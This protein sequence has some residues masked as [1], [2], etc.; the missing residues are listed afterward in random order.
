MPQMN[1]LLHIAHL[2]S[3]VLPMRKS[4]RRKFVAE[5]VQLEEHIARVQMD[6]DRVPPG[7]R[8]AVLQAEMDSAR[9]AHIGKAV[10]TG[11]IAYSN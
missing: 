6:L 1:S 11:V 3:M 10:R 7:D 4:E 2:R 5:L 9:Q 8:I